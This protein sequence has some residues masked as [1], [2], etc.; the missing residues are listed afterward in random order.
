MG[1]VTLPSNGCVTRG[2]R[3]AKWPGKSKDGPSLEKITPF[4]WEATGHGVLGIAAPVSWL[5]SPP[6]SR[7]NPRNNV[8]FRRELPAATSRFRSSARPS[9]VSCPSHL[10][11]PDMNRDSSD[12]LTPSVREYPGYSR[13][14]GVDS[15]KLGP[16]VRCPP[17]GPRLPAHLGA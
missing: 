2:R 14:S 5:Q 10:P 7:L 13:S 12:S 17:A 16:T 1:L 8:F 9:R 15:K 6:L 4:T 3:T 11:L